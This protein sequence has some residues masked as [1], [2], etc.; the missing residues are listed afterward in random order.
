MDISVSLQVILSI[1]SRLK[2]DKEVDNLNHKNDSSVPE[3]P[4]D[5]FTEMYPLIKS[6]ALSHSAIAIRDGALKALIAL[7]PSQALDELCISFAKR[8]PKSGI[9]FFS[10]SL[11]E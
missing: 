5:I 4:N 2:Y 1:F 3:C 10:F 8:I 7:T 6:I 9:V 11:I